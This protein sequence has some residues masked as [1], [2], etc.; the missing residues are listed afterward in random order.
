MNRE[1]VKNDIRVF[2]QLEGVV[3]NVHAWPFSLGELDNQT[4]NILT[5]IGY[6]CTGH[7]WNTVWIGVEDVPIIINTLKMLEED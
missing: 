2:R 4:K 5:A 1:S 6:D 7:G 3:T